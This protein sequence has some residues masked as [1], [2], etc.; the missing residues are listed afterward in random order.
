MAKTRRPPPGPPFDSIYR[1]GFVRA[2]IAT[3][4][5]EVASPGLQ[6]RRRRWRSRAR[7]P[8]ATRSSRCFPNSGCRRIRTRTCSS[9]TRCWTRRSH[10]LA[11]LV[12]ASRDLALALVVGLPLRADD[13]LFNCGVLVHRGRILGAVPKSYL[14]NYREFYEK[15]QFAPAAQAL[16]TS[17]PPA[18]AGRALRQPAAVRGDERARL[19]AAPRDLRG[20]VGAA[21][22]EHAR[23]ARRRDRDREPLGQRHHGRQGGLPAAALRVAV[24]EVRRRRTSIPAPGPGESTTDLAWDGHALVYENGERLA[25]SR[26]FPL[27]ARPHHRRHRPRPPAPGAHAAHELRRQRAGARRRCSRGFR[28]VEFELDLPRGQR[29][30]RAARRALPVRARRPLRSSTSA[31]PRSTTSRSRA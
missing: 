22:A 3:P 1:H 8:R 21:A 24:G 18:R 29:A 15:R 20:P 16:S 10:A 25:E 12:D 4:R 19:R 14:P 27:R 11:E 5:V 9:R 31:A 2:A 6:R 23:G 13:R 26:R 30:A 28:R 7:R 17:D